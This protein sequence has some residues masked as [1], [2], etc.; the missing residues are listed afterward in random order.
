MALPGEVTNPSALATSDVTFTSDGFA[1]RGY[2]ARPKA[3]GTYPGV[4]ILH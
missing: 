4:I 2:L 3:A 1:M